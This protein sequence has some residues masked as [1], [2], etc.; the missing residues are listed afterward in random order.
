MRFDS[1]LWALIIGGSSGFGLAAAQKLARHGM[2]L[3]IVHRDRRGAMRSIEPAFESL[4]AEGVR[5]LTHNLDGLSGEGRTKVLDALAP[6]LGETGKVRLLLHTVAFGN[7][8]LLAPVKNEEAQKK[9]RK[10]LAEKLGADPETISR[11]VQEAFE[12]GEHRLH[13][14][15]DPPD[16]NTRQFLEES[17]FSRTVHA[18]GHNIVEWAADLFH[19]GL[20]ADDARVLSLTSEGNSI[21]WRGYAAVSAAKAVLES[22]S[23]SMAVEFAPFGIRSNVI[24]A[25][26]TDTPALAAIPGS[27]RIRAQA[28][29]RNPFGRLTRP[30]DVAGVVYLLCLEEAAWINGALIRADGGESIA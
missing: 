10:A 18:M 3:C 27:D 9:S 2:N 22:V 26:V 5:V 30:E 15:V 28:E 25:G 23:R 20:F 12:N 21:A 4:R 24:Q 6:A 29:I 14:L 11:V 13:A 16:Y 19:R 1:N 8:K 7:L 17:D